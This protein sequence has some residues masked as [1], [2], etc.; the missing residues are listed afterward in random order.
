[1]NETLTCGRTECIFKAIEEMITGMK[2]EVVKRQN[3][4]Y[5]EQIVVAGIYNVNTNTL[6]EACRRKFKIRLKNC[7]TQNKKSQLTMDTFIFLNT[8]KED[9]LISEEYKNELFDSLVE[10]KPELKEKVEKDRE[11]GIL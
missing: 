6:A 4:P 2:Q 10:M 11:L 1:M 7:I 8:L 5:N 9:G 3:I